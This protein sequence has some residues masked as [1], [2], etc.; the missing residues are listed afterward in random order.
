MT[1]QGYFNGIKVFVT[2]SCVISVP[3]RKH[4]KRRIQKKWL[5]RYGIIFEP[6]RGLV[7]AEL[8]NENVLYCHPKFWDKFIELAK[9]GGFEVQCPIKN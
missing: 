2:E 3:K 4:K 5:K 9:K 8:I 1:L 7:G 6:F